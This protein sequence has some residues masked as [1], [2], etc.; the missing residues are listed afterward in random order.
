[1]RRS[2]GSVVALW[3]D[4]LSGY[5]CV[6]SFPT[7]YDHVGIIYHA[8]EANGCWVHESFAVPCNKTPVDNDLGLCKDHLEELVSYSK[9]S[10]W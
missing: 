7:P 10:P 3:D 8:S 2:P 5:P 1:M 4:T 6:E 9:E